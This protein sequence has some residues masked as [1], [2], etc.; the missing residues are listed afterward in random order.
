M[1]GLLLFKILG[2]VSTMTSSKGGC[3]DATSSENMKRG[4]LKRIAV[5]KKFVLKEHC[6]GLQDKF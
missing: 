6:D 1:N 2:A 4:I 3:E 5:V